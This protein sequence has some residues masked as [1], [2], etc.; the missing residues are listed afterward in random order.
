MTVDEL[1]VLALSVKQAYED[2]NKQAGR[3]AWDVSDYTAG[4]VG[5]MGDLSKLVMAKQGLRTVADVDEK[6][7]HELSDC[8][9]SV[10]V[11]A[12]E[13]GIDLEAEFKK[14]MLAL[15]QRVLK[16]D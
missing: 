13:L 15:H 3:K 4:F 7:A 10:L 16:E 6:L 9:W 11:I 8:L 2:K 1:K 12:D 5:D 14:N